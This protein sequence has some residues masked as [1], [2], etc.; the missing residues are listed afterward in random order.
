MLPVTHGAEFT[1]LQVLLYTLV[2]FAATLLPFIYGMSGW[3]YLVGAL[4]LGLR[5]HRLRA[6]SCGA[7]TATRWRG[8][9]SA[10]PSVYL[11]LLFAALL[12]DH[13]LEPMAAADTRRCVGCS[14]LAVA[15]CWPAATARRRVAEAVV[16]GGRHHRRRVRARAVA[17]RRRRQARARWPTSRARSRWSSSATRSAPTSARRR[18]PN[19]PRSS[20]TWAPTASACRASSSRV[21][22][23]ARHAARC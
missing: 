4:V 8:A 19:W 16:Q 18:W 17:A 13:Y 3:I 9:P 6:G 11:S 23:R 22:P 1:R 14:P 21:D 20:A 10:S 7:T 15:A 12:L 5:L 2:L